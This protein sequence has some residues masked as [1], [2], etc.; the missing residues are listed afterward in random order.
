M[1]QGPLRLDDRVT[2]TDSALVGQIGDELVLLDIQR[3][4]CF[5]LNAV[6]SQVWQRIGEPVSVRDLCEGLC[7]TYDVSYELCEAQM[8]GLLNELL[9]EGLAKVV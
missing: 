5:G 6:G 2:L 4:L 3:G 1:F 9:A 8:I 7:K